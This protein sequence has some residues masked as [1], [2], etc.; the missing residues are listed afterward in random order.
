MA[1]S[2]P[3]AWGNRKTQ[4]TFAQV[5]NGQ[6]PASTRKETQEDNDVD[7]KR[8]IEDE[9]NAFNWQD[10]SHS[11]NSVEISRV[12]NVI[13]AAR[14]TFFYLE[15][16]KEQWQ[17]YKGYLSLSYREA[18]W[19]ERWQEYAG[20]EYTSTKLTELWGKAVPLQL[21]DV[22]TTGERIVEARLEGKWIPLR[23]ILSNR[24]IVNFALRPSVEGYRQLSNWWDKNGKKFDFLAL[25]GEIRNAV[26]EELVK[27]PAYPYQWTHQGFMPR[28]KELGAS[29][30]LLKNSELGP[31]GTIVRTGEN[32]G[33][34]SSLGYEVLNGAGSPFGLLLV[35]K[36]VNAE[37]NP[38]LWKSMEFRFNCEESRLARFTSSVSSINRD[39][40][41]RMTIHGAPENIKAVLFH[42]RK[43]LPKFSTSMQLEV[44]LPHRRQYGYS[45]DSGG[46]WRYRSSCW[47]RKIGLML[48]G[49]ENV[50]AHF[51]TGNVKLA[52]CINPDI[53]TKF[54][55][56][57]E[58]IKHARESEI[59]EVD[60]YEKCR[61]FG[62]ST[63]VCSES[64]TQA[65]VDNWCVCQGVPLPE[66]Y[67]SRLRSQGY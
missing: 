46:D 3:S 32:A 66:D 38:I 16:P 11:L 34:L 45:W 40:L 58:D 55:Q 50:F 15:G 62:H 19:E 26:Y 64:Y 37:L 47:R 4:L 43:A 44:R 17:R 41:Q 28:W 67:D 12:P 59:L 61:E 33:G 52:G 2:R 7:L 35:N 42:A 36:Q 30:G 9:L 25:P 63:R 10:F 18:P 6:V 8:A 51:D 13:Q 54:L 57:V 48:L 22:S 27:G 1:T 39:T 60:I 56:Y 23:E 21:S 20:Q 24:P 31:M 49:M 29:K 5:L 65:C 53:R 14:R